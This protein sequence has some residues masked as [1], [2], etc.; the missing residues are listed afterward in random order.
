MKQTPPAHMPL[1]F[2]PAIALAFGI[3]GAPAFAYDPQSLSAD[4]ETSCKDFAVTQA[5]VYTATCNISGGTASASI[6]LDDYVRVGADDLEWGV[7]N[8]GGFVS[9]SGCDEL[10]LSS[11]G[12]GLGATCGGEELGIWLCDYL[13]NENGDF[14]AKASPTDDC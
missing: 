8:A 13:E 11:V 7:A 4:I 12:T 3:A 1:F 14:S 9:S 10:Y 2:L 5:G 6:A